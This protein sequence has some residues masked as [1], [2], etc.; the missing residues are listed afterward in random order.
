MLNKKQIKWLL[1]LIATII[2][3]FARRWAYQ[4]A[5]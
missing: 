5:P 2:T 4:A 3:A 1:E